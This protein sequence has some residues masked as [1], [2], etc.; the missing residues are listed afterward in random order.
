MIRRVL[1]LF[2]LVLLTVV[3]LPP[4]FMGCFHRAALECY[5]AELRAAG[6]FKT[7]AEARPRPLTNV[8]SGGPALTNLLR[9]LPSVPAAIRFSGVIHLAAGTRRVDWIQPEMPSDERTNLWPEL[10]VFLGTNAAGIAALRGAL[11]APVLEF[12]VRYEDGPRVRLPHLGIANSIVELLGRDALLQLHDGRP[13]LALADTIAGV[14]LAARWNHEPILLT[15]LIR[16]P[17]AMIMSATTWEVLQFQGW[18]DADLAALQEAWLE[19]DLPALGDATLDLEAAEQLDMLRH[20]SRED[21]DRF[22]ASL[23]GSG[24][25]V[26]DSFI[27]ILKLCCRDPQ[28]GIKAAWDRYP[29]WWAFRI[30]GHYQVEK[31]VLQQIETFRTLLRTAVEQ[32]AWLVPLCEAET[33]V[34]RLKGRVPWLTDFNEYS[35]VLLYPKLM[36]RYA[37]IEA[38]RSLVLAAIALERHR[39]KHGRYPAGLGQLVPEFLAALPR[40]PMNGQSLHYSRNEDGTFTLYSV[41][42]NGQDDGGDPASDGNPSYWEQVRDIVWPKP[43]NQTEVD[44]G[45]ESLVNQLLARQAASP[46]PGTSKEKPERF[47]AHDESRLSGP[48]GTNV[49]PSPASR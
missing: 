31:V 16:I 47:D 14:H 39:L 36:A 20:L 6:H 22:S 32:R 3:L 10:R 4:L 48:N 46:L 11:E 23:S 8:V 28:E 17:I 13:G 40:D 9:Q 44:A 34:T 2:P 25:E 21:Y 49:P 43:A 45:H 33:N 29:R 1:L 38:Q 15:Q 18:N 35:G 12:A 19:L 41:G 30:W 7:L 27:G 26:P 24:G 5:Q 37:G 42:R